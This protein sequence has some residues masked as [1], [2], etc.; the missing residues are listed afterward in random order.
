M[1]GFRLQILQAGET[2]DDVRPFTGIGSGVLE[3]ALR[4]RTD[5]FRT[6]VAVQLGEMIYVLYAFQKKSTKGIA[7]TQHDVDLIKRRYKEAKELAHGEK[8]IG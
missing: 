4:Y 5:A 1:L 7:T 6:V 3:I 2:P 8:R